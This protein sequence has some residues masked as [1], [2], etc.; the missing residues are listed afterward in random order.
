MSV[1]HSP[2]AGI[3]LERALRHW[4]E[5][6]VLLERELAE[7]EPEPLT[8]AISRQCGAG[9][10]AVGNAIGERLDWP[11]YDRQLVD[12]IAEDAGVR[13]TLLGCLDEKRPNWFVTGISSFN[14]DK[15]MSPVGYAMRMRDVLLGLAG[16]GRC[17]VI[18][19]GAAQL[20]PPATTL[21]LRL[22]APR[23]CR[24]AH[25][26]AQ[27]SLDSAAAGRYV[28]DMDQGRDSFVRTHFRRDPCDVAGYDLTIDTSRIDVATCAELAI[29]AMESLRRAKRD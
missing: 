13:A 7:A 27:L 1:S 21:R 12:R 29:T 22:I 28:D 26:A 9:A 15:T 16:H 17:V 24:V 11:V 23:A 8:I 4:R 18:G 10:L 14:L 19:R 3:A 5:R 2:A 6:G 25:V 20:L